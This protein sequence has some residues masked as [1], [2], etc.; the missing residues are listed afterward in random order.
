M[1][2]NS[3]ILRKSL[4]SVRYWEHCLTFSYSTASLIQFTI[5]CICKWN[6][7][8]N[9]SYYFQVPLVCRKVSCSDLT[10]WHVLYLSLLLL[11]LLLLAVCVD[12]DV[13]DLLPPLQHGLHICDSNLPGPT[14]SNLLN[15]HSIQQATANWSW[16][17]YLLCRLSRE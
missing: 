12:A 8:Y 5:H 1:L 3:P 9:V 13:A 16:L 6:M 4:I 2:Q 17:N 7:P 10:V 11:Q 14:S 15:I